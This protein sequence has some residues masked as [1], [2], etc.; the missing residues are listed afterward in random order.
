MLEAEGIP[1]YITSRTGYFAAAEVQTVLNFLRV[2]NNPLQDIPLFGV[3]KKP[4]GISYGPGDRLIRAKEEQGRLYESL[5][6]YAREGEEA[7]I[8]E[9]AAR[10]L[11]LLE[12]FRDF[13][14]LSAHP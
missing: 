13:G 4:G 3:L 1:V 9:K 12:R 8:R 6:V 2:L 5:R 7:E 14:R 10:F 11:V